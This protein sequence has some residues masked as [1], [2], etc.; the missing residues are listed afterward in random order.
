VYPGVIWPA[1]LRHHKLPEQTFR[2]TVNVQ[3]P[4]LCGRLMTA[5]TVRTF[6]DNV[7]PDGVFPYL[8]S[9][10]SMVG[11]F[12]AG[13]A[14]STSFRAS[15]F[16]LPAVSQSGP[17]NRSWLQWIAARRIWL[18]AFSTVGPRLP[19]LQ[20]RI[21][22]RQVEFSISRPG[23]QCQHPAPADGRPSLGRGKPLAGARDTQRPPRA[24]PNDAQ[25]EERSGHSDEPGTRPTNL[26]T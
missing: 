18:H 2:N 22:R 7:E 17:R 11:P 20:C 19:A 10:S 16:F 25:E 3:R 15:A 26:G 24:Y 12:P 21:E 9:A 13:Q 8:S 4:S 23:G 5:F 6:D 14:D 1:P